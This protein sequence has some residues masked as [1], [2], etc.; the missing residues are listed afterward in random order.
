M[1]TML[2]LWAIF[3]SRDAR[4]GTL[5]VYL[6]WLGA[7]YLV[8]RLRTLDLFILAG[9]VL[10]GIVVVTAALSKA[11]LDRFDGGSLLFIGMIVIGM[12]AAGG[13]WLKNLAKEAT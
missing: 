6:L 11:M 4:A 1:A 10:S 3:D 12:S 2:A 5:F 13:I 8:Y 7:L 9:G